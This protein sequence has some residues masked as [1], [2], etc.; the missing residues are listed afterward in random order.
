[1]RFGLGLGLVLGLGLRL[2]LGLQNRKI[3]LNNFWA[4]EIIKAHQMVALVAS[5]LMTALF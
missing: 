3:S 1:M 4:C 5:Y 2:G